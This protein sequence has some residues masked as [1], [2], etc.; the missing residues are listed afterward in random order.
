MYDNYKKVFFKVIPSIVDLRKYFSTHET[1]AEDKKAT[2]YIYWERN[3]HFKS[4]NIGDSNPKGKKI[5]TLIR[6]DNAHA[7]VLTAEPLFG[8][9]IL[10]RGGNAPWDSR[11]FLKSTPSPATFPSAH[12]H[13]SATG[14][15]LFS[16]HK[17]TKGYTPETVY[18]L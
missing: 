9:I 1:F 2:Q 12:A 17:H 5:L 15:E 8:S 14:I 3:V 11:T 7:A 16:R 18:L 6:F 10:A 13:C 4:N